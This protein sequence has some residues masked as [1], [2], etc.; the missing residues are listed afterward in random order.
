MELATPKIT[1]M[2]VQHF[3]AS[4]GYVLRRDCAFLDHSSNGQP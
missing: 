4:L 2:L 1:S 3:M